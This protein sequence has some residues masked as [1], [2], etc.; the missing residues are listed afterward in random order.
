MPEAIFQQDG[1]PA[2]RAKK[3]QE[4]F[5]TNFPDFWAKD[6]WPGNSSG[7]SPIENL[8][9]LVQQK[10]SQ[11]VPATSDDTL[12]RKRRALWPCI[13]AGTLDNLMSGMPDRMRA[14][15]K[16]RWEYICK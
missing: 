9:A 1:A 12:M 15:I 8:W 14:C 7:L 3:T 13:S 4:W 6:E 11:L 2:H 10:L 16:E 5:R